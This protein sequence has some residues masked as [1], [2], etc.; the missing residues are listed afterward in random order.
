MKRAEFNQLK[1]LDLEKLFL[2][3]KNLKENLSKL[4]IDKNSQK[5]KDKREFFKKR[6]DLAKVLTVLRQ[7]ELLNELESKSQKSQKESNI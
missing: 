5:L 4:M 3:V 7:K 2:Q 1:S 6:K